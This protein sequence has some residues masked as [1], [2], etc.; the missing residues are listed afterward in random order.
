MGLA[1]GIVLYSILGTPNRY[2]LWL[3]V[4]GFKSYDKG[5]VIPALAAI[6]LVEKMLTVL[7]ILFIEQI[8]M[9]SA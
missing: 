8:Q 4:A 5:C 6:Y 9:I 3:H 2:G 1:R 7:K